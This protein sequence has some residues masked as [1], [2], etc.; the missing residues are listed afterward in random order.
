MLK[1]KKCFLIPALLL[2]GFCCAAQEQASYN[3]QQDD[4]LLRKKYFDQSVKKKQLL[5]ASVGKENA[6]DYKNIY[7]QQFKGIDGIW[8]SSR[9]VTSSEAHNYLQSI[10]QKII[11]TNPELKDSDARVVFSRDWWPNAVSM[12]DGTIAINAGL[13]MYIDRKSV[14]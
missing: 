5:I 2:A 13:V 9:P 10:V 1:S 6:A 14:V 11:A 12:G 8:T 3:F 7:E 4:T